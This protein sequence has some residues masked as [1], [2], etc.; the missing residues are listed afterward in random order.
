M[1]GFEDGTLSFNPTDNDD[2]G[3]DVTV[4][5][6]NGNDV[7]PGGSTETGN[8]SVTFNANGSFS[9]EPDLDFFGTDTFTYTVDDD[10]GATS[11]VATVTIVSSWCRTF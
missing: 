1:D 8:G 3:R 4:D 10:L 6:I 5:Q 9:Y 7:T 2:F 11:N